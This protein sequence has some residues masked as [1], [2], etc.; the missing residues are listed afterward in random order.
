MTVYLVLQAIFKKTGDYTV[1]LQQDSGAPGDVVQRVPEHD[2]SHRGGG[3]HVILLEIVFH[4]YSHVVQVCHL[5]RH[6]EHYVT[7]SIVKLCS[8]L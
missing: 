5:G 1:I 6:D 7:T 2:Q 8:D 4:L 3:H